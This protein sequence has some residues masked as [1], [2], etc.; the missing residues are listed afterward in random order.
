MKKRKSLILPLLG[1][2]L[3]ACAVCFV[4]ASL[5]PATRSADTGEATINAVI[6]EGI[7]ALTCDEAPFTERLAAT[8]SFI[9]LE[10][11]S[12]AGGVVYFNEGYVETEYFA[13]KKLLEDSARFYRDF[14]CL[15]QLEIVIELEGR[16]YRTDVSQADLAGFLAVDFETL[17]ADIEQ[18]R[19]FLATVDKAKVEAFAERFVAIEGALAPAQE[20]APTQAVRALQAEPSPTTKARPSP[21]VINA[22]NLAIIKVEKDD[23]YVD[24]LN[25]GAEA[26]D[27]AGWHLLSE[28]GEQNCALSGVIQPGQTLRVWAAA[29]ETGFSCGFETTIWNNSESD[30]AVLLDPQGVEVSR[31]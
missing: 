26:V 23:E 16:Q 6:D 1:L 5:N 9:D 24:I 8:S 30:P 19:A 25:P 10:R 22:G 15:D 31:R 7:T 3:L 28:K 29:G 27:L 21:T 14:P 11:S 13:H 4:A 17:H 12:F 20:A 18:W 2:L